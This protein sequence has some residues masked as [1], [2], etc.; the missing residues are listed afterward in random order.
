VNAQLRDQFTDFINQLQKD[1]HAD[2]RTLTLSL[3]LPASQNG[4]IDTGAYD[5]ERL[6][7]VADSIE[8]RPGLDQELYFQDAETGLNYVTGKVDKSKLLLAMSSMSVE[9]G[10]DGLRAMPLADALTLA[11]LAG[12]DVNGDIA[13]SAQVKLTAQNLAQSASAS[14]MHWDDT[15]RAVTFS[16]PGRG[17]KR[18]VWISNE[19]SAAYRLDLVQRFGLGGVVL[20]DVS[21]AAGASDVYTAVAQLADSGSITL[22]KPN[23]QLLVPAWEASDGTLDAKSGESVTWTAPANPGTYEVTLIVS[24]G[25]VRASQKLAIDVTKPQ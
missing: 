4:N 24:D 5:W 16:Y 7:Q 25:V 1:L 22:T 19:F 13:P 18:T 2:R 11:S 8:I 20:D 12:A 9:R 3:P 14:G 6:G 10:T 17:G 23:G 15:A 21:E